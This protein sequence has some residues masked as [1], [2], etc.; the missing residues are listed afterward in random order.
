MRDDVR[1]LLDRIA[2]S[3]QGCDC[4]CIEASQDEH[5]FWTPKHECIP[6]HINRIREKYSRDYLLAK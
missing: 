4:E 3:F 1:E 5:G 6:C 2:S